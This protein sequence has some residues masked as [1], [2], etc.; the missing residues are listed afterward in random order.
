MIQRMTDDENLADLDAPIAVVEA[1]RC[2]FCGRLLGEHPWAYWSS[3]GKS[4]LFCDECAD[5]RERDG[6]A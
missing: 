1:E 6:D 2:E 5:R 3:D 4:A